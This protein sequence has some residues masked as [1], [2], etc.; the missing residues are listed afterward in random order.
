MVVDLNS[1]GSKYVKDPDFVIDTEIGTVEGHYYIYCDSVYLLPPWWGETP[2]SAADFTFENDTL[3][4]NT[5]IYWHFSDIDDP[6]DDVTIDPNGPDGDDNFG[7]SKFI[8]FNDYGINYWAGWVYTELIEEGIT[9]ISLLAERDDYLY[10]TGDNWTV[11]IK[12]ESPEGDSFTTPII[13]LIKRLLVEYDYAP[14]NGI[15]ISA[16][17]NIDRILAFYRDSE[18]HPDSCVWLELATDYFLEDE[19]DLPD[20]VPRYHTG[21]ED[22][23]YLDLKNFASQHH[24]DSKKMLHLLSIC[25]APGDLPDPLWIWGLSNKR[26]SVPKFCYIFQGNI[27][28]EKI[29]AA[30]PVHE[31]GHQV[32]NLIDNDPECTD[33]YCL[34]QGGFDPPFYCSSCIRKIRDNTFY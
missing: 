23:A 18:R 14:G 29:R 15:G 24:H 22:S 13:T 12:V 28:D 8:E 7:R 31:L 3:P 25:Y 5:K 2:V 4:L 19:S 34:M 16:R 9:G 20:S 30:T 32:A 6:A 21:N 33:P 11:T 10:H 17:D 1:C 27:L 26:D